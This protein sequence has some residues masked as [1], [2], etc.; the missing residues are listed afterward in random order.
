MDGPVLVF[1]GCYGNLEATRA[2]MDAAARLAIPPER[3][4][5]TGDVVAYC[6]D[7]QA[8]VDLVRASGVH[9]V[10]GN[11]E[12]SLGFRSS[13]C[14]CGFAEGSA[15]DRL[16]AAWFAH[17]DAILDEKARAWMRSL[18]RRID[19]AVGGKR[20][21]VVH[22]S[23]PR[24]NEFVFASGREEEIAW[25]IELAGTDG[26]LA[27]HC[28]LPFTR[29]VNGRLWH[30]AGAVGMPADDGTPRTWF[31]LIVP[32]P[33]GLD[34]RHLALDYDH[35]AAA[36]KARAAGLP[37]PY[38]AAL[39][40]GFWPSCDVLPPAELAHR[41]QPLK[42]GSI[43]WDE[44]T[45]A[46]WP[47][48][49]PVLSPRAKFADPE[50]TATGE[51]RAAVPLTALKTLWVNTGT[52]CNL[53]CR[54][55]YIESSPKN[56]RL[57]YIS[58]D[59]VRAFLDEARTSQPELEEIG[60]TGGE[61]F[62]NPD[63]LGIIEDG[64]SGGW[65]V[66]VLTNAMKPMQRL[67]APLLDLHRRFPGRLS[68]RVSL[69]HY[70]AD[71]H[72]ELRGTRTWQPTLEGLLW[73]AGNGF[74]LAVAGRTLWGEDE[75]TMRSGYGALFARLGVDVDSGDPARLVLFPE[76]DARTDVSE[77]TE[78]C[79]GVLGKTPDSVMCASSRMV[80]KRKGAA[81]PSVVSCTLLPYD[82][83][84]DMGTTL[85]EAAR[86][87]KLNHR[88]CAEFCVLGG[89]SCSTHKE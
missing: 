19:L 51:R 18:P 36:A 82:E 32:T 2:L 30:N 54:N 37:E 7:A 43:C 25:Q 73:L 75:A 28:G 46:S 84:F 53:A 20:L 38:A 71:K 50:V 3:M 48:V 88:F 31:S 74:D 15:C 34:V 59:E 11:C 35:H 72:E 33:E 27:G 81:R 45:E 26:V 40:T 4:V 69:D 12:E 77:I 80:V 6:A 16:S 49:T 13:D 64:L 9:V 58:R 55:C 42:P 68:L 87:V 24:I 79:W 22:G 21:A 67:K 39:E 10:M 78:R 65:R 1:G 61:P 14:G 41:G 70:T 5:C 52:L 23:V 44:P 63:I 76:M 89:A 17:A 47:A 86:P 66:L 60:L 8:T 29:V 57:V 85:A 62:M 56:D 83:A